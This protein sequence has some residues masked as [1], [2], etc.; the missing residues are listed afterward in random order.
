MTQQDAR[1]AVR[2]QLVARRWS[3][4]RLA[5]EARIDPGTV[6]DFLRGDTAPW[7][8]TLGAIEG[9]LGMDPGHLARLV[10]NGPPDDVP[11]ET[12]AV[13]S[14][15]VVPGIWVQTDEE[16]FGEMTQAERLAYLRGRIAA[17]R[18]IKG[19]RDTRHQ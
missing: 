13:P 5:R 8:I 14:Y 4:A 19:N 7:P 17:S 9:A 1:E 2:D 18:E 3:A 6:G 15:E 11:D 12:P 10:E 16:G